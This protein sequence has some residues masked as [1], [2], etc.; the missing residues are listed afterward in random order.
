MCGEGVEDLPHIFISGR[1]T[2]SLWG[3]VFRWLQLQPFLGSDPVD[4]MKWCDLVR[5]GPNQSQ[6]LEVVCGTTLWFL[7]RF[8][9][10]VVHGSKTLPVN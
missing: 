6:V 4:L 5:I 7:W 1:V 8:R 9:N 2:S 10:D 3:S